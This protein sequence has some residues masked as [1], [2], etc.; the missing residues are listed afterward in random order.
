MAEVDGSVIGTLHGFAQRILAC[1]PFEAGLPPRFEVR[2]EAQSAVAFDVR[3]FDFVDRPARRARA[4][5]RA[6]PRAWCA[7][8][9]WLTCREIAVEFNRNWDLVADHV[10][11]A[12]D[13][14]PVEVAPLVAILAE[15][16]AR[17][18]WCLSPEDK[19]ARHIEGLGD[20]LARLRSAGP[21]LEVLQLLADAPPLSAPNRGQKGNWG[22]HV[23]EMRE[24]LALAQSTRD[25]IFE[26]A[27]TDALRHLLGGASAMSR[28]RGARTG[29]GPASLEFHDLLVLARNPAREHPEVAS[30]LGR[31]YRYLL[32]DEFQDTDPIQI[33]LAVRLATDDPDAGVEGVDRALV[34]ARPSVLCRGSQAGHLPLPSR[35]H[36]PV[37]AGPRHIRGEPLR[38]TRNR[39]S[40]PG[41]IAWVNA[42]FDRLMGDGVPGAQASHDPLLEHRP[43]ANGSLPAVPPVVVLGSGSPT[44]GNID[45]IRAVESAEIAAALALIRDEGWPVGDDARPA[46]LADMAVLIPNAHSI[47]R[48]ATGPRHRQ[49]PVPRGVELP[50]LRDLRGAGPRQHPASDRRPRRTRFQWWL[51]FVHRCSAA[52]M[53]TWLVFHSHAGSWDYRDPPPATLAPEHP[54]VTAMAALTTLHRDRWWY[55]VSGLIERVLAERRMLELGLDERRPREVWRRLRFVVD[56]ARLFTDTDTYSSD[57]RSY[58]AWVELQSAEDARV[59]EAILPETDDDAVRIMT[60]HAS[61][62]LEFPVVVLAGLNTIDRSAGGVQVLWGANGPEVALNALPR[63]PRASRRSPCARWRWIATNRSGSCTSPPPVPA[64]IWS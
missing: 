3:W 41:V 50:C 62:G 37:P 46:R 7:A 51:H 26:R 52:A 10:L 19:L 6:D 35:R 55:D 8:S 58:L 56:H 53:T 57:L 22:G 28:S 42:M 13:A 20:Y 43:E 54:V 9:R 1:Y 39:R 48:P 4:R 40:V 25:E 12:P 30:Q 24:L 49:A 38:L 44:G 15:A 2:D 11:L 60:V 45:H 63:G 59:V 32:I 61:K 14:A 27:A 29:A 34:R 17:T 64:T 47:A 23:D 18:S 21:E 5:G 16:A 31:T 33:E 36:S